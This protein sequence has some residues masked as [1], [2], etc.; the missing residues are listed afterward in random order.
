MN[1]DDSKHTL[2][3]FLNLSKA[4]DTI[5]HQILY[6]LSNYGIRGIPQEWFRSYL[7]DRP[8]YVSVNGI[9]SESDV[10][11]YGVPQGSILGPLFFI[12]YINDFTNSSSVLS[13]IL[14][15]DDSNLFFSHINL[16]YLVNTVNDEL[17]Q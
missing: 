11:T 9:N 3:I 10:L 4:L 6:K 16:N 7:S 8:Q 13:F 5:D 15:A 1:L 2:G 14:F 12:L 17:K